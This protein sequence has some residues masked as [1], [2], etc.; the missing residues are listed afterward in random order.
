LSGDEAVGPAAGDHWAAYGLVRIREP[1]D[2]LDTLTT[3]REQHP[4]IAWGSDLSCVCSL[5]RGNLRFRALLVSPRG[6][7]GLDSPILH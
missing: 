4:E 7:L 6:A 1:V 5:H 3:R 2:L